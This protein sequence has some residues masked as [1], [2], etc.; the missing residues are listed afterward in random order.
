MLRRHFTK[1][2]PQEALTGFLTRNTTLVDKGRHRLYKR[3]TGCLALK[4]RLNGQPRP[5][6]LIFRWPFPLQYRQA[7][8]LG[9]GAIT[10][11]YDRYLAPDL[12]NSVPEGSV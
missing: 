7:P 5:T 2:L 8:R 4:Q 12:T 6:T 9:V 10:Y 3:I 1:E 11:P